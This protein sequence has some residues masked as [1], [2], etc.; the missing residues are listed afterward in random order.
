MLE[1]WTSALRVFSAHITLRVHLVQSHN[2]SFSS[3][4]L[5]LN[6]V[7]PSEARKLKNP[8][9]TL[10]KTQFLECEE[11]KAYAHQSIWKCC[12]QLQHMHYLTLL[13]IKAVL[14]QEGREPQSAACLLPSPSYSYLYHHIRNFSKQINEV[15]NK[16]LINL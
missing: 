16:E 11:S 10:N 3:S 12:S 9:K 8:T 15:L 13:G 6:P 14:P 4:V 2:V 7:A 5:V 1:L